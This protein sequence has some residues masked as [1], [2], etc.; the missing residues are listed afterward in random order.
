MNED[1]YI[2]HG[3]AYQR[4]KYPYVVTEDDIAAFN[5]YAARGFLPPQRPDGFLDEDEEACW[6]RWKEKSA[7]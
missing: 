2:W 5:A 1:L 7:Q 3:D 4:E 6:L